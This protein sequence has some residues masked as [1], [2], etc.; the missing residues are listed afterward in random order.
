M[1]GRL[2]IGV[3]LSRTLPLQAR[4]QLG[5]VA[6]NQRQTTRWAAQR[7]MQQTNVNVTQYISV[8]LCEQSSN[9]LAEHEAFSTLTNA[10]NDISVS[11]T[12]GWIYSNRVACNKN[13]KQCIRLAFE[14]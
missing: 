3:L 13:K 11:E 2:L 6:R 1:S 9:I 4:G 10:T 12:P 7:T 8:R 14:E 5:F